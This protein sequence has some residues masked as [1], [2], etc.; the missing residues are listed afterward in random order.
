MKEI[1]KD[2]LQGRSGRLTAA[3]RMWCYAIKL[4]RWT[5]ETWTAASMAAPRQAA[6]P[7]L[8]WQWWALDDIRSRR[9]SWSGLKKS[10]QKNHPKGVSSYFFF[11]FSPYCFT[12]LV[13]GMP[14]LMK[15]R[16]QDCADDSRNGGTWPEQPRPDLNCGL[17]C[18]KTVS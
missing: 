1:L 10:Y 18:H 7:S 4:L 14:V 5:K 11:F 17:H 9:E 8:H 3:L 6:P 16:V 2:T 13:I 12:T 15:K